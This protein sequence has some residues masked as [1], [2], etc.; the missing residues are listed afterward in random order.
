MSVQRS[1]IVLYGIERYSM[2]FDVVGMKNRSL[3]IMADVRR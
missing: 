2:N 1:S 3:V